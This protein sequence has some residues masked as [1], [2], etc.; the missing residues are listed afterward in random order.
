MERS[1]IWFNK[2][3]VPV[4]RAGAEFE[5]KKRKKSLSAGM[6]Y[7]LLEPCGEHPVGQMFVGYESALMSTK[8]LA[9][10]QV[11]H[12]VPGTYQTALCCAELVRRGK[13][14]PG[15]T[16]PPLKAGNLSG[17]S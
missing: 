14:P 5:K 3:L 12:W 2:K 4:Q 15:T 8:G 11:L 9:H 13:L 10:I 16:T 1:T 7:Y 6:V 17:A